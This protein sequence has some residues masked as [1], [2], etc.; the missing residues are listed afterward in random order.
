MMSSRSKIVH[1][2]LTIVGVG[3]CL[4]EAFLDAVG[5]LHD[6]PAATV[7]GDVEWQGDGQ[8]GDFKVVPAPEDDDDKVTQMVAN[9][10]CTEEAEA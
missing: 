1:F 2:S 6:D 3:D 9:M 7:Y 4:D 5:R 8:F 10:V